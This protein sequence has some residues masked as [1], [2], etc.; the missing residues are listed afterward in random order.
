MQKPLR[1]RT[2]EFALHIVPDACSSSYAQRAHVRTT[3]QKEN[4]H[5]TL[6]NR[7]ALVSRTL[8]YLYERRCW[9]ELS[10]SKYYLDW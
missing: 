8:R 9:V 2:F 5:G 4:E 1:M 6:R 7:L 3:L 10:S